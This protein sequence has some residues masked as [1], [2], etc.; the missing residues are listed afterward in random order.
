ML[1]DPLSDPCHIPEEKKDLENFFLQFMYHIRNTSTS[2][3]HDVNDM[4]AGK[5]PVQ[6]NRVKNGIT[7]SGLHQPPQ[8]EQILYYLNFGQEAFHYP[9]KEAN[10]IR[11]YPFMTQL[12][13][14]DVQ[15][16]RERKWEEG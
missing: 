2:L 7:A 9:A 1:Q 4:I 8:M 12:D 16:D 10:L 3:K 5:L 6:G 13:F 14:F 11:N 15:E